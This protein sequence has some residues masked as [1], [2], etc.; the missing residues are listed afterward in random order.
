MVL[1]P[2][3]LLVIYIDGV[4]TLECCRPAT[5][6]FPTSSCSGQHNQLTTSTM[7]ANE[8]VPLSPD[9]NLFLKWTY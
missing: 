7:R 6:T 9:I 1:I 3:Q 2:L 8:N 5:A 4:L